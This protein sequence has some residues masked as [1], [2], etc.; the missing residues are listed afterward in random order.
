MDMEAI[1]QGAM[2]STEDMEI[3][4]QI[5]QGERDIEEIKRKI[6]E[7]ERKIEET[8]RKIDETERKIE[9]EDPKSKL[10]LLPVL[11]SRVQLLTNQTEGLNKLRE[12]QQLREEQL[13][14]SK[15]CCVCASTVLNFTVFVSCNMNT[16][17]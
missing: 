9:R 17:T 5:Q 12:R 4:K 14:E 15:L 1:G 6:E 7:T 11:A 8:E 16:F 2:A 13:R 3:P 10:L